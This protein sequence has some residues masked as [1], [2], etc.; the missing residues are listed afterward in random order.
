MRYGVVSTVSRAHRDP[1][2]RVVITKY[3]PGARR[4]AIQRA[5]AVRRRRRRVVFRSPRTRSRIAVVPVEREKRTIAIHETRGDL[6]AAGLGRDFSR[7]EFSNLPPGNL[8][9]R[10]DAATRIYRRDS[11]R[12]RGRYPEYTR[13]FSSNDS[14]RKAHFSASDPNGTR[15]RRLRRPTPNSSRTKHFPRKREYTRPEHR[16]IIIDTSHRRRAKKSKY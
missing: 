10:F 12:R 16:R 6:R 3:G 2:D 1:C 11:G 4:R 13:N 9:R 5:V 7:V 15:V 14:F 8:A